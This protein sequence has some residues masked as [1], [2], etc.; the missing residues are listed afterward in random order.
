MASSIERH[1]NGVKKRVALHY[2]ASWHRFIQSAVSCNTFLII[3]SVWQDSFW[4]LQQYIIYMFLLWAFA[5]TWEQFLHVFLDLSKKLT[6]PLHQCS[7]TA[8]FKF[9]GVYLNLFSSHLIYERVSLCM[10]IHSYLL[11]RVGNS[12]NSRQSLSHTTTC[13]L[14]RLEN[15]QESR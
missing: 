3:S 4:A 1:A 9:N 13:H 14:N 8:E 11:T 6:K 12:N 5:R 7:D 10:Q 2:Y 15:E